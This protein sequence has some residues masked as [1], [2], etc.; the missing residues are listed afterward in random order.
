VLTAVARAVHREEPLPWAIDDYLALPMAGQEGRA[1]LDRLRAEVPRPH[2]LAFSRW[3]CVR[4]RFTED[5]VEQAAATGT[6]QYVILGAGLDSFAYRRGDLLRQLRVFEVDHPATQAWKRRR[7]AE[8]GI[9]PPVGL[10]FAPVDFEHQTLQDALAQAG[11]DFGQLAVVSWVGVTMYLTLDAIHAT[12]ATLAGCRPGSRVVLTY[13]QPPAALTGSTAQI[14]A[15]F[16]ALAADLG[17]PFL[18]RFLPTGIAQLLHQHGFGQITDFGPDQA[19]AA[20]FPVQADV[21]IAGAQRL[22]AA[23]V[24]PASAPSEDS[25]DRPD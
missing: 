18:S 7:L 3:M 22:I 14:A 4:A 13:N 25:T 11:F 24:P 20:Y 12:L 9:Q 1:L 8:L 2:L 10:V 19:R 5:I 16:A 17:E 15:T 23:T 6:S 21:E